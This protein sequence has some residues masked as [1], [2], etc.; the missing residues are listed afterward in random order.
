MYL[1][2]TREENSSKA[3]SLAAPIQDDLQ[4]MAMPLHIAV[5]RMQGECHPER[6]PGYGGASERHA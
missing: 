5:K 2:R 6:P 1:Q 3:K 4:L